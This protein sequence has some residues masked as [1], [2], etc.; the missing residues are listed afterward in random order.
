MTTITPT[1]TPARSV[2]RG[3]NPFAPI[4]KQR[5]QS[6][7]TPRNGVYEK[8]E[9]RVTTMLTDATAKTAIDKAVANLKARTGGQIFT[10]A[11]FGDLMLIDLSLID[12]N[13][14]IQR[15]L[16]HKHIASDIIEKFDPRVIQP[17]NVTYIKSTGRYSAWDGQQSAATLKILFDAGLL[18]NG[19]KVQCKVVDE[20]L[21]VPG[22]TLKGEAAGNFGFRIL[23]SSREAI[24]AF[25]MFRSRVSGVR[26]YGSNMIE[27]TQ[28]E[29]IQRVLE[30][31]HMFPAKTSDAQ[32]QRAKPGMVTYITGINSIAGYG[33]EQKKFKVT[34][35]DLE[36]TLSWHN[37][38]FPNE[39]GVD[40]GFILAF[41]RLYAEAREQKIKITIDAEEDL[42]KLF[43]A[44][45]GS[46][47]GFHA[48]CKQRLKAFQK[49][50][51]LKDS[52]QDSCLTPILVLDYLNWKDSKN[53]SLPQVNH[54][55]TYAGI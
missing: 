42:Y 3:A 37:K 52:W 7:T 24:D 54:M 40:G 1:V 9:D 6:L 33:T 36:H 10:Q 45:Y 50:N 5:N 51:G 25:W 32:G 38:Y 15:D 28:A 29:E 14:D 46:P 23:N 30:K 53:Y 16:I 4:A 27:D 20:D 41:G 55:T 11:H 17:I 47:K 21:T 43:Q 35:A 26:N 12:I 22:S 18:N 34:L 48:D 13:V 44:K 31:N 2:N 19:V 39:K 8:L 49:S